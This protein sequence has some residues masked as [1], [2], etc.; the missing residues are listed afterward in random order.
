M[1]DESV[2]DEYEHLACDSYQGGKSCLA[3]PE[4]VLPRRSQPLHFVDLKLLRILG[5]LA[6][7][8][9]RTKNQSEAQEY[10]DKSKLQRSSC[11]LRDSYEWLTRSFP[12]TPTD[13]FNPHPPSQ[14]NMSAPSLAPYILKRP[15]L[16]S[17]MKPFAEWYANA[18]GY[19][20]LGRTP[21]G[22]P[23]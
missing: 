13:E 9:P 23:P 4:R 17:W 5:R 20:R 22:Q 16:L 19:R 10:H 15:W 12:S 1:I 7:L 3:I 21:Q 2:G 11:N 14:L 6:F 8:A 18:A